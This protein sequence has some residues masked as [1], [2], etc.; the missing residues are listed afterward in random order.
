MHRA[1]CQTKVLQVALSVGKSVQSRFNMFR[2]FPNLWLKNREFKVCNLPRL[3]RKFFIVLSP[4]R[5]RSSSERAFWPAFQKRWAALLCEQT[6]GLNAW[7]VAMRHALRQGIIEVPNSAEAHA[8]LD[9]LDARLL[10]LNSVHPRAGEALLM[11]DVTLAHFVNYGAAL[12]SPPANP[13]FLGLS[14]DEDADDSAVTDEPKDEITDYEL[15]RLTISEL[16]SWLQLL[17]LVPRRV[18]MLEDMD[19]QVIGRAIAM[20]LGAGFEVVDGDGYTHSKS[21]L[22]SADDRFLTSSALRVVF[23]G[24]VVYSLNLYHSGA[25]LCPDVAS[26]TQ[27]TLTLPWHDQRSSARRIA[28]LAERISNSPLRSNQNRWLERLE[29]FRARRAHLVAGN[30]VFHRSPLLPEAR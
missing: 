6:E 17:K 23:P 26:F 14:S 10:R 8:A 1:V 13:T 11:D 2:V 4:L 20:Q 30:S 29:F 15:L 22:V 16:C 3:P 12:L 28:S 21:L 24:Q 19:S 18:F 27:P 7:S 9:R 5:E 25:A